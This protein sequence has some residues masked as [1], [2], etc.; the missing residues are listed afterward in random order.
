MIWEI[1]ILA[2]I[3]AFLGMRLYSVLGNKA[4]HEEEMI[5]TRLERAQQ[6]ADAEA[7][8]QQPAPAAEAPRQDRPLATFSPAIESGLRDISAADRQFQ[9][10]PF[11]EGAKGAYEVV[12][13]AFWRGDKEE[14]QQLCD[15]DVYSSFVAAIDDREA[16]GL[17]LDNRLIRIEDTT[18]HSAVLDG[19]TARIAVR[20]VADIASVTRDKDGNVIAGSL[21]DAIESRDVWTFMRDTRSDDPNWLLDETDAG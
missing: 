7:Q 14:L 18:I 16:N 13:D 20:F 3:A 17:T 2:M 9:L 10:L 4:E 21:D 12:L 19:K 5:A 15:D 6:E 11:M 8:Q 1:V